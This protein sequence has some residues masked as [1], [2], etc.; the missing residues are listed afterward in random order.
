MKTILNRVR[1]KLKKNNGETLAEVLVAVLIAGVG[2]LLLI[3]MLMSASKLVERGDAEVAKIYNGES[4]I[5][6][7]KDAPAA[8]MPTESTGTITFGN[9]TKDGVPIG[10]GNKSINVTIYSD[11]ASGLARYD[12]AP[13][14][15]VTP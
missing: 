11:S 8:N 2:M 7:G 9:F 10:D 14:T 1:N 5:E 13:E 15:Q 6:M 3:S 4:A 12:K